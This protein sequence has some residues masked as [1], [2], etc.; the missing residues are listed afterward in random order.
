[1]KEVKHPQS[2]FAPCSFFTK[3]IQENGFASVAIVTEPDMLHPCINLTQ[4]LNPRVKFSVSSKSILHDACMMF[5]AKNL[6]YGTLSTLS[7]TMA[8]VLSPNIERI[9]LAK[10]PGQCNCPSGKDGSRHGSSRLRGRHQVFFA[11]ELEHEAA[12]ER[13]AAANDSSAPAMVCYAI[14][15]LKRSSWMSKLDF[16]ESYPASGVTRA[17][18]CSLEDDLWPNSPGR[19]YLF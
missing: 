10:E 6:A 3:V 4:Q 13:L 9:F 15:A 11:S 14:R 17:A 18:T 16:M 19:M 1:L 5:R 2:A 8:E 12:V 7:L